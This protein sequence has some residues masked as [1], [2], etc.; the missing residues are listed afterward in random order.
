MLKN[1]ANIQNIKQTETIVLLGCY[2]CEHPIQ[3]CSLIFIALISW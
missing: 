2:M 3:N 1:A